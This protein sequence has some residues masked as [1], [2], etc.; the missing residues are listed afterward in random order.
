MGCNSKPD[1]F[2]LPKLGVRL[3]ELILLPEF[4]ENE[5]GDLEEE[6]CAKARQDGLQNA[7]RWFWFQVISTL[8]ISIKENRTVRLLLRRA[9]R[10]CC[11]QAWG[12]AV[13]VDK[14][15]TARSSLIAIAFANASFALFCLLSLEE[16][17]VQRRTASYQERQTYESSLPRKA[18]R[19][20]KERVARAK[21]HSARPNEE[22]A[23]PAESYTATAYAFRGRT[24]SGRLVGKG[25]I[26]ADTRVLP[27]GTRVHVTPAPVQAKPSTDA[28]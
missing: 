12:L 10:R 18:T 23:A 25:V 24:A 26:A 22:R 8:S 5:V 9:I 4:A 13:L 28:R 14:S 6:Y 19:S 7:R 11:G 3:L 21:S 2:T 17:V 16:Q 27:M 20:S 15:W 1:T